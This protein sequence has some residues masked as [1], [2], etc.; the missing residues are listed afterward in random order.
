MRLLNLTQSFSRTFW[1]ALAARPP[2]LPSVCLTDRQIILRQRARIG[3]RIGQHLVRLV[4]SLRDL[5][6]ALGGETEAAVGFA[7]QRCEVVKA[8]RDLRA[9][10]LFLRHLRHRLALTGG[11][12]RLGRGTIPQAIDAVVLVVVLF[13]LGPLIGAFVGTLRDLEFPGHAPIVA[14]LE[15]PNLELAR[16]RRSRA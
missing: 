12:D 1:R 3:P 11:D 9:A 13:E 4:K 16:D 6:G 8:R 2:R 15:I 14:R 7:L 10:F 5:Q